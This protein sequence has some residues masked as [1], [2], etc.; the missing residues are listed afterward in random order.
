MK[1][2][3][4]LLEGRENGAARFENGEGFRS[5]FHLAL[6]AVNG[7]HGGDEIHA[8]DELPFHQSCANLTRLLRL[9]ECAKDY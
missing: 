7:F 3:E 2:G 9:G 6:P 1:L 5:G 8:R 4:G